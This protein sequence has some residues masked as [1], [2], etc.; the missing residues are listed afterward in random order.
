MLSRKKKSGG[1]DRKARG[2]EQIWFEVTTDFRDDLDLLVKG[3]NYTSRAELLRDLV[4]QA[5]KEFNLAS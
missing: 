1:S 2:K 5:L 3:G 4:R